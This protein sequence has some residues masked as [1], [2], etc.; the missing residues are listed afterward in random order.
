M[1]FKSSSKIIFDFI[2]LLMLVAVYC[3]RSTGIPIHKNIGLAVFIFFIIHLAYNHKW[4]TNVS[5]KLFDKAIGMRIKM[6]YVVNCLLISA[7][8]LIG[9]SGIMIS[10]EIFS[11]NGSP[12]W[13]V[14][15]TVV[16][17]I[18]I[19]LLGIH[20]GL[21]GKM[22]INTA[23]KIRLPFIA[24]KIT[25]AAI[26]L[27]ILSVG[28]YGDI[29]MKLETNRGQM[30]RRPRY[31]TAIGLFQR[32]IFL[33][34]NLAQIRNLDEIDRFGSMDRPE[35]MI[36]PG[37]IDR[38]GNIDR[39]EMMGRRGGMS[40]SEGINRPEGIGRPGGMNGFGGRDNL[41]MNRRMMGD[42][43]NPGM[44]RG[45]MEMQSN[46]SIKM[47]LISVSNYLAFIML[48]SIIVYIIDNRIMTR[49]HI[50]T[51]TEIT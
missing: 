45:D 46:F 22:I 35:G 18:S 36:G 21:H 27:I 6:M 40:R 29:T 37:G 31:E 26:F 32:S 5:K 30:T 38:P 51:E 48:C 4:I 9:L 44:R 12:L 19:I 47:L 10:R 24:I 39:A 23:K 33:L 16:S 7:F 49:K 13:R 17:M 25:T 1:K 15:H 41:E 11:F 34:S 2:M 50:K 3:A 8:I 14:I 28:I 42:G 20:I 43:N